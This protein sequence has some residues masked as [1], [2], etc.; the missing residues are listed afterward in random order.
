MAALTVLVLTVFE[1]IEFHPT[2]IGWPDD[3][4]SD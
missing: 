2:K 4:R 1:L 3:E